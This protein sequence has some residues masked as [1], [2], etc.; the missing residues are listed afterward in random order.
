MA[1]LRSCLKDSGLKNVVTYIQSGNALF[2]SPAKDKGKLASK[3]ERILSER[4]S[5]TALVVLV[6]QNELESVLEKAPRGFGE[7]PE[8][9]RYDV[10]FLRP[11]FCAQEVLP[12]ISL[13]QG[14]DEAFGH[15]CVLYFQRLISRATQ[16]K[17][18]KLT[19][20]PAYKSMTVRSWNTTSKLHKL[21]MASS[22]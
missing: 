17:L 11:P 4:F 18:P 13:K 6:S 3:V 20:H 5:Y 14:V 15:D 19:A 10:I 21:M 12:T 22:T 2:E 9:Y 1:D 16:S 8:T 7:D